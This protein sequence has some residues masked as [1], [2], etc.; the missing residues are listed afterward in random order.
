MISLSAEIISAHRYKKTTRKNIENRKKNNK[1]KYS[2]SK[3]KNDKLKY[4]K[5][6]LNETKALKKQ[7]ERKP[8]KLDKV[9]KNRIC[10]P[11][12]FKASVVILAIVVIGVISKKIVK[13]ENMP[14]LNVFSNKDNKNLEK[15]YDMNLGISKLDTTD[16]LKTKNIVLNELELGACERL[17]EINKDYSINFLAAESIEKINNK[18]YIV[19]LSKSYDVTFN[20][21][22]ESIETI[23]SNTENIYYNNVNNIKEILEEKD[24][25]RVVLNIDDPYYMYKLDFPIYNTSSGYSSSNVTENTIKFLR[26][27]QNLPLRNIELKGYNDYDEMVS[28]FRENKLDIF[29]TS[30]NEAMQMI[31]KHE[32]NVKKYRDGET[33]FLLGNKDSELF[34]LKEVRKALAYCLRREEIIKQI[35]NNFSELIDIPFIYSDIKY[36]YDIYGSENEL[37]SNGWKKL[38]GVYSKKI[39]DVQKELKLDMLVNE[40][41]QTKIKIADIIKQMASNVGININ[42]NVVKKSEFENKLQSKEYDIIL[43]DIYTGKYPDIEY[44]KEYLNI[45]EN[46][47]N[48]FD[49]IYI[50]EDIGKLQENIKNLQ[51]TISSEIACIGIYA[52]NSN[53]VYQKYIT[54]FDEISY[55]KLFNNIQG[56]GKIKEK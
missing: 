28:D 24:G 26:N 3:N 19:H 12:I 44:L 9:K 31:G 40:E 52:K 39:N 45:N 17:L 32:Y 27:K 56:I 23:K 54:G 41:D 51:D 7:V 11:N 38:D 30:S 49:K 47:N 5:T 8:K 36:K 20:M 34:S 15:D 48:A 22:K 42:V 55:F 1:I 43:A 14:V 29:F 2:T 37:L 13:F 25:I 50:S 6:K 10:I 35:N 18:E 46:V 21:V 16:V 53:L 4:K 33:V